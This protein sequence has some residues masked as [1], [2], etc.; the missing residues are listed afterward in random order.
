MKK[1][2]LIVEDNPSWADV[3]ER[4]A[5]AVGAEVMIALSPGQAL[6]LIDE[7]H[8]HAVCLDMLLAGETGIALL[9]EMKSHDDLARLPVVV[10]SNV[11]LS[12]EGMVPFGVRW[13]LDKAAMTPAGVRAA[14]REALADESE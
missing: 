13:V 9:Q 7:W 11:D 10:C 8:P 14:F 6:E 5:S 3:L 12:A 2:L 1:R 4:H